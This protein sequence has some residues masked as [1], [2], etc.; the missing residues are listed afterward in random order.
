MYNICIN[1]K[2]D[3]KEKKDNEFVKTFKKKIN[4]YNCF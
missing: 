2:L 1:Y 3:L 4:S